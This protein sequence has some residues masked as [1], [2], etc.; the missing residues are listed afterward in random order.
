MDVESEACLSTWMSRHL[1]VAA[2]VVPDRLALGGLER[3]VL[4]LLDPPL[5]LSGVPS[6]A[7]RARLSALRSE[8]ARGPARRSPRRP[9]A[10]GRLTPSRPAVSRRGG[11]LTPNE[12]A[13]ELGLR[14]GKRVRGFLR[15]NFPRAESDVRSRWGPLPLELEEAVRQRFGRH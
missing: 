10:A 13:A 6:S 9:Q 3:D 14:D 7:A 12:L 2:L 1:D 11:G 8:F 5:N 4:M 15:A